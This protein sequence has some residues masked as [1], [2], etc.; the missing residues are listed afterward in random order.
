[1]NLQSYSGRRGG[2]MV[3]AL[4][5]GSE[6]PG[7]SPSWECCVVFLGKISNPRSTSLHPGV[8]VDCCVKADT[9]QAIVSRR[10]LKKNVKDTRSER[11]KERYRQQY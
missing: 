6:C 11:L 8:P 5:S 1:M 10:A 3:C 7:S 4:D 9:W 2:L